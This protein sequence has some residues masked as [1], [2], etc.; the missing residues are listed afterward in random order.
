MVPSFFFFF[1]SFLEISNPIIC[2]N[3]PTLRSRIDYGY[4]YA[5]VERRVEKWALEKNNIH[6]N[7][8]KS[9]RDIVKKNDT[10]RVFFVI[11]HFVRS[12]QLFLIDHRNSILEPVVVVQQL[13]Q[14][15]VRSFIRVYY[16]YFCYYPSLENRNPRLFRTKNLRTRSNS[17]RNW[18]LRTTNPRNGANEP[19]SHSAR[20]ANWNI[21]SNRV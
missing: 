8:A 16:Y 19:L 4:R 15:T 11:I 5:C 6:S 14:K 12:T 21:F 20:H 10:T 13:L 17:N 9:K 2:R 18:N 3:F 7:V 1:F